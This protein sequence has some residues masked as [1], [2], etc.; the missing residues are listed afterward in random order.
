MTYDKKNLIFVKSCNLSKHTFEDKKGE[1]HQFYVVERSVNGY[2]IDPEYRAEPV[3]V[4]CYYYPVP[5]NKKFTLVNYKGEK[6]DKYITIA[7]IGDKYE[8][9]I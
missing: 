3:E 8:F 5:Y 9:I 7:R 1:K 6:Y 2:D 4:N